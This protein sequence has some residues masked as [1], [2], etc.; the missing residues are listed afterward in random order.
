MPALLPGESFDE[1]CARTVNQEP[2]ARVGDRFFYTPDGGVEAS[3]HGFV[4]HDE[5][6]RDFGVSAAITQGMTVELS[7]DIA[8]V[9]P[10]ARC[11]VRL[12]K[13]PG[14]L[15]SPI[16]V[17]LNGAGTDWLFELKEVTG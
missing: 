5:G 17:R 15:W 3:V 16:N 2:V 13:L 4:E 7:R 9:R 10:N 12:P 8:P 1:L 11:R 14:Q 6:R